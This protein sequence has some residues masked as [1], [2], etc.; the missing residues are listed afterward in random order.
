MFKHTL[1]QVKVVYPAAQID[2]SLSGMTLKHSRPPVARRLLAVGGP[3][4]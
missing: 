4:P 2:L 1:T 3:A